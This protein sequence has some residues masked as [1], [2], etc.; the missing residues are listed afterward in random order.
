MIALGLNG[1]AIGLD[2][3]D[4]SVRPAMA[5]QKIVFLAGFG[6]LYGCLMRYTSPFFKEKDDEMREKALEFIRFMDM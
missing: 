3:T 1:P 5:E 4:A 6:L 2:I